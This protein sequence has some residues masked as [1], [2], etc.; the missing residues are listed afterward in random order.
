MLETNQKLIRRGLG[1]R[2]FF[3]PELNDPTADSYHLSLKDSQDGI[4]L[5]F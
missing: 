4:M 2:S 3:Y 1:P 5:S